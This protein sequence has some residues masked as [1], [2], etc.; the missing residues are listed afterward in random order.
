MC[1][2]Q[3]ASGS[4]RQREAFLAFSALLQLHSLLLGFLNIRSKPKKYAMPWKEFF[5]YIF[6]TLIT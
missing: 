3:Y 5:A 6:M 4:G 2:K 1:P